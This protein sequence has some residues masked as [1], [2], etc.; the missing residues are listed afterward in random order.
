MRQRGHIANGQFPNLAATDSLGFS[1][2]GF[3]I[4]EDAS[5]AARARRRCD[6]RSRK[7]A[8]R[9]HCL[10]CQSRAWGERS[11]DFW[12]WPVLDSVKCDRDRMPLKS[13]LSLLTRFFLGFAA[14]LLY[15]LIVPNGPREEGVFMEIW[16]DLMKAELKIAREEF[17]ELRREGGN[18]RHWLYA[19][20]CLEEC[21]SSL[22]IISQLIPK[23]TIFLKSTWFRSLF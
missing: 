11:H 15:S 7:P 5:W 1:D 4:F 17:A 13:R 12:S 21:S 23:K 10:I 16:C 20:S 2:R 9:P 22:E 8:E 18:E 6:L 3:T 19:Q 14:R